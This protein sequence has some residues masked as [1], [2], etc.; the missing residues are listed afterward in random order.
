MILRILL[1][2]SLAAICARAQV[3]VDGK[4][5]DCGFAGYKARHITSFVEKSAI[6]KM[7]PTYPPAVKAKS[8]SGTVYVRILV[9]RKGLV[10]QTCPAFVVSNPQPDRR[11]IISAEAAAL[12]WKYPPDFGFKPGN[13]ILFD[14]VEGVVVFEFVPDQRKSVGK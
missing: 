14:Y 12:Q 5:G 2:L 1:A 10:E 4:E 8:I 3:L 6:S 7:A 11:L 9:N 13:S